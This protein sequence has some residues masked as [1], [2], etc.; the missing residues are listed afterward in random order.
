V[1]EVIRRAA[2][3]SVGQVFR[4]EI[5]GPLGADFFIGVP[6][7]EDHRAADVLAEPPLPPGEITLWDLVE[8]QPGTLAYLTFFNPRG[9]VTDLPPRAWRAA[10]VPAANGH[11]TA[12]ALARIYGALACG[13][14][15]DG[16]RVLEAAT[17][18]AATAEES[19][20]L[21]EILPGA[22]RFG[23]G[24]MLTSPVGR[25]RLPAFPPFGPGPR[26]FGHPG[27][28]GSI[29]FADPDARLGFG[30]VANQ[31]VSGNPRYPDLR[32]PTL[33]DAVYTS[34]GIR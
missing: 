14:A 9:G 13:G 5:A 16:V 27:R 26:A 28:G 31:Y 6:E 33:V 10:E 23:L 17:L 20:G 30:Y 22:T 21:D 2:G 19:W 32:W 29:G 11:T 7:S 8:S 25:S 1:G 24:F 34:L 3:A 15:V 12:R 18:E 4:N